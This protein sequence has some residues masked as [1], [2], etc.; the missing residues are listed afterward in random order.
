MS[1]YQVLNL[2]D[3][4]KSDIKYE[5]INFSDGES[6][7]KLTTEVNR[8]YPVLIYC[9]ISSWNDLMI[10]MQVGDILNR[11]EVDIY[12]NIYYLLTMRMDRVISFNEAYSLKIIANMINSINAK[13]VK[14]L[15][16]HSAKSIELIN[17]SE[18]I[19]NAFNTFIINEQLQFAIVFP[20]EGAYSRYSEQ[21]NYLKQF[22]C[23]G[24]IAV[25]CKKVRDVNTGKL[26]S[27]EISNPEIITN[28]LRKFIV[29][30]DLCD[31]GGTFIGISNLLSKWDIPKEIIITHMVNPN[32]ITNLSTHY[33]KVFITNSYKNW[34]NLPENVEMRDVSFML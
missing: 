11:M 19:Y 2:T 17:N 9:R 30:D 7:I 6:H 13:S 3:V 16:P 18:G 27:F 23:E 14:I 12:L 29:I 25:I 26:L 32:G 20:D 22:Y 31:N 28:R 1:S 33:H 21:F 4:N 15:E 24:M 5:I 8:K 10:L 34:N